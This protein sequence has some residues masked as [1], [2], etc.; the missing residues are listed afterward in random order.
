MEYICYLE[1]SLSHDQGIQ[2]YILNASK[3]QLYILQLETNTN[4]ILSS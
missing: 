1:P 4:I 3:F 2:L